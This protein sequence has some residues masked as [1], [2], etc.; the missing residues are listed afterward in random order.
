MGLKRLAVAVIVLG[1]LIA[2]IRGR[3]RWLVAQ[4]NIILVLCAALCLASWSHFGRFHG[5]GQIVHNW[6]QFHYFL[7]SKYF[8]EVRY[9][10]LYAAAIVALDEQGRGRRLPDRVRDQRSLEVVSIDQV[11]LHGMALRDE[12]EPE[13]WVAFKEDVARISIPR[14]MWQDHGYNPTPA[15]TFSARLLTANLPVTQTTMRILASLDFILLGLVFWV[16]WRTYGLTVGCCAIIIF[17]LNYNAP[18]YWTGGAFLR[19]DWLAAI[20]LCI[21]LLNRSHFAWAG[22]ALAY[23]VSVRVFPVLFV[24]PLGIYALSCRWHGRSVAWVRPFVLGGLAVGAL[25]FVGGTVAGGGLSVWQESAQ[26]LQQHQS[27]IRGND[28]GLKMPFVVGWDNLRGALVEPGSA[29]DQ[30][31]GPRDYLRLKES[32]WWLIAFAALTLSLLAAR[33]AWRSKT[34]SDA[35]VL[36]LAFV[37]ALSSP[38][39]YYWVM[40]LLLPLRAPL[41]ST[42]GFVVLIWTVFLMTPV[43]R[44]LHT[45][46][47]IENFVIHQA[48]VPISALMAVLF[49]YWLLP[50]R[51]PDYAKAKAPKTSTS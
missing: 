38:T 46:G 33:T 21:C 14:N 12:F 32:R 4:Q 31:A 27:I 17:G 41:Q 40:L 51:D 44:H 24:I 19:Q 42:L 1:V 28:V 22:A 18:M 43:V 48:F 39:C 37:F 25:M 23:A 13:R 50:G 29:Y 20:T 36:G 26:R 2:L 8:P 6:E 16:L 9:E 7:G 30:A 45:L 5:K 3:P 11:Q 35:A 10:G 47:Y 34:T 15:W 49:V